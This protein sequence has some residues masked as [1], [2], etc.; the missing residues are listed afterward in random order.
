MEALLGDAVGDACSR[1]FTRE[2]DVA[3]AS[4]DRRTVDITLDELRSRPV[5]VSLL[6]GV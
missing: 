3:L 2:G 6:A 5:R 1:F 4:V